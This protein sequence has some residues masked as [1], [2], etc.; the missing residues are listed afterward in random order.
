VQCGLLQEFIYKTYVLLDLS[1]KIQKSLSEVYVFYRNCWIKKHTIAHK[2]R[3]YCP[4]ADNIMHIIGG[5][6][7]YRTSIIPFM[8]TS[9]NIY[10]VTV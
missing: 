8:G 2:C 1:N 9:D 3:Y 5:F 7:C 10:R 4:L 6:S